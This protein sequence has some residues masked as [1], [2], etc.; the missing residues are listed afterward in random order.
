MVTASH[1]MTPTAGHGQHAIHVLLRKLF[2]LPIVLAAIWFEFRG[3]VLTALLATLLY[4][5]HV[6]F[7]WR[8]QTG[9]NLNQVGELIT[10]WTVGFLAG[11]LVRLEKDALRQTA[12]TLHGT[13]VALVAALDSREHETEQH[14]WRVR[15]CARAIADELDMAPGQMT[16]LEQAS[17][18]HDVGKI[19]TPDA[20]LLKPGPLTEKERQQ[21]QQHPETG[22]HILSKVPILRQVAD[23][24]YCHHE[25]YDGTGYPRGIRGDDIPMVAR[26]FAVADVFDALISHRP[27]HRKI[28]CQAAREEIRKQSGQAFDPVVVRAFLRVPC[29]RWEHLP[30]SHAPAHAGCQATS[31][32][33]QKIRRVGGR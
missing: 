14:S 11:W 12:Q 2:V 16:V 3:V 10:M 32:G 24:V 8:G 18:L 27:Y 15:D 33:A 9:E 22:R 26:V 19:G 28:S 21:I 5:P 25:R 29:D 17:L 31:P 4:L 30:W 7:Q 1:W 13:L 20:I 23:I 6:F